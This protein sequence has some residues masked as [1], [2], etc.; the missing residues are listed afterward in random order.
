VNEGDTLILPDAPETP[1][2]FFTPLSMDIAV[3]PLVTQL[4]VA[5]PPE[6]MLEVER[7]RA[8]AGTEPDGVGAAAT[9]SIFES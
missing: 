7:Y 6:G 3:A 4:S 5:E 1:T 2:R 9:I 8:A